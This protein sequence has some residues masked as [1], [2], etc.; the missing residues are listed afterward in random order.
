V[1]YGCI[2]R[3]RHQHSV[4]MMC[5]LLR[6]SRSGYYEWCHRGESVKVGRDRALTRLIQ[7]VYLESRGV[8]GARKVQRELLAMETPCGRHRVARLMRQAGL[9]GCPKRR[10]RRFAGAPPTHPTAAN[11]LKQDFRASRINERWASDI[12]LIWT[13]QGW[14]FLAVVMDLYS[15]RIVGW[16][17]D[18]RAGRG[19]VLEAITMALG[20]RQPVGPLLHH[21]DRGPQYTSD[22]FR[23]LL[24]KHGIECSMSARGSC[25]DN[26]PVESFFSL[27]KRERVRRHTYPTR[28][29]AKADVFDYIERFYNRKRT[30]GYL[31]YISPAEF[32]RRATGT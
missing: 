27:L 26:A 1:R 23:D 21:S 16:S 12:T 28:E 2:H 29:E 14:L 22:D 18:R 30:H 9:K 6:V 15:R 17:M 25:Y 31:D 19:L 7:Q 20:Y 11:L 32:E 24:A 3:R 13:R 4:R 10:F 5:R 8:Y